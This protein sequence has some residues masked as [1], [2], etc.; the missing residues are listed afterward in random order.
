MTFE[1]PETPNGPGEPEPGPETPGPP[2]TEAP[3]EPEA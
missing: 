1:T 3:A 2:P